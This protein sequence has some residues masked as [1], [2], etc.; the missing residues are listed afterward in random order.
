MFGVKKSLIV[1]LEPVDDAT[2]K[3]YQVELGTRL[4]KYDFVLVTDKEASDLRDEH[5]EKALADLG[6]KM[7]LVNGL[8]IPDVD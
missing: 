2:A 1:D 4:L 6:L 5:S 8:P 3:Q 7:K